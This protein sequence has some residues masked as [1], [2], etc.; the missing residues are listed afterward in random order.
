MK[1]FF[2][3]CLEELEFK[4][5]IR[6]LYWM[7]QGAADQGDFDKKKN[8]LLDSM[9]IASNKFD[10]IPKEDQ[11]LIITKM[12]VE[13]QEYDGMNSRTVWK[14]LNMHS[15]HYFSVNKAPEEIPRIEHTAEQS[16]RINAMIAEYL[17]QLAGNFSPNYTGLKEEINRIQAEDKERSD[18]RKAAVG[19]QSTPEEIIAKELHFEYLIANYDPITKEK[20]PGWMSEEEFIKSQL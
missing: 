16:E 9:V 3:T 19:Y 6:Q 5:G 13:D 20:L 18:G 15:V 17:K 1:D 12:M 7:Q 14:W 8:I 2:K 11:K 10:Y 4:T